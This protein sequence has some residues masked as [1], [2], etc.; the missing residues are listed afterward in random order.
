MKC[1]GVVIE[2]C[3]GEGERKF[4]KVIREDFSD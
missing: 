2:N 4:L 1:T 3:W